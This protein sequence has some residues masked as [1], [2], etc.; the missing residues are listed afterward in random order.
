MAVL[1]TWTLCP[2]EPALGSRRGSKTCLGSLAPL[3]F[4]HAFIY[5]LVIP[6]LLCWGPEA[7]EIRHIIGRALGTCRVEE[8]RQ[9]V[10]VWGGEKAQN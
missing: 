1:L 6:Y 5:H 8:R 4:T 2:P 3:L 10:V 9:G 7:S